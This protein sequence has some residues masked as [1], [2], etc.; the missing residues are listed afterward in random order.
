MMMES[1]WTPEI[2]GKAFEEFLRDNLVKAKSQRKWEPKD[3]ALPALYLSHGAPPVF[4]D[5]EWM[6]DFFRWSQSLPK[7]RAIL[8]VSAHWEIGRAHV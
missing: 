7:P 3:G 1:I 4:D 2:P 6:D 8:I 5:R